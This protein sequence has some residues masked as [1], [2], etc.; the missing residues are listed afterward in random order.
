MPG[1][2]IGPAVTDKSLR[3]T[4]KIMADLGYA[5]GGLREPETS[6]ESLLLSRLKR[7]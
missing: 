6:E 1:A 3:I 5:T 4:G 7:I 2:L